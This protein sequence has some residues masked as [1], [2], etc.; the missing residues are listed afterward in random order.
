MIGGLGGAVAETLSRIYPVKMAMVGQRDVFG[1][2]GKPQELREK[3]G[4]T[5]A[6]IEK[7]VRKVL[8]R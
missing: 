7:A 5:A 4:M 1:E 8:G 3:Y 2:S 6:D